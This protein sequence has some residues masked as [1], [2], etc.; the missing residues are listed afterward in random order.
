MDTRDKNQDHY[1][2][3]DAVNRKNEVGNRD[4]L[5]S[6]VNTDFSH[7]TNSGESLTNDESADTDPNTVTN[8]PKFKSDE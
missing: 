1:H 2:D 6:K 5:D 7:K 3:D 8:K 4:G